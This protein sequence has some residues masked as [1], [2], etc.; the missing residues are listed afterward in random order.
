[1]DAKSISGVQAVPRW[2]TQV[3][4]ARRS[5]LPALQE[6]EHCVLQRSPR[7]AECS[8]RG[9]TIEGEQRLEHFSKSHPGAPCVFPRGLDRSGPW[10][11]SY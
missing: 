1:M 11:V 6:E 4:S 3:R 5:R 7:Q 9:G 10:P 2:Q 8:S